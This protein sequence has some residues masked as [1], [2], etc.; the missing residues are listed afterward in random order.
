PRA[1]AMRRRRVPAAVPLRVRAEPRLIGRAVA[2]L[3]NT[4]SRILG[5]PSRGDVQPFS[6]KAGESREAPD[7][8]ADAVLAIK[9]IAGLVWR[10]SLAI[11]IEHPGPPAPEPELT[12]EPAESRQRR[13]R[14]RRSED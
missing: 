14:R 11:R 7:S 10:G 9:A 1:R 6:L 5:M 13:K 4:S 8:Y 12:D 2:V 3:T